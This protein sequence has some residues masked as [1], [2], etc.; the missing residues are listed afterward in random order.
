MEWHRM[1]VSQTSVDEL[2]EQRIAERNAPIP[3]SETQEAPVGC[4][5]LNKKPPTDNEGSTGASLKWLGWNKDAVMA[6]PS[7][8]DPDTEEKAKIRAIMGEKEWIASKGH[9][10]NACAAEAGVGL[11]CRC[12]WKCNRHTL[13]PLYESYV[14]RGSTA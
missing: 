13:G 8:V 6:N 5:D 14:E 7:R 10:C 11:R 3:T 12:T 1:S 4:G 9:I 2:L